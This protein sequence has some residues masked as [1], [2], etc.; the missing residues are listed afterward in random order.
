M[1]GEDEDEESKK[2]VKAFDILEN[3]NLRGFLPIRD[4][5]NHL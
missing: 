3:S 2:S 1:H 4:M 5:V